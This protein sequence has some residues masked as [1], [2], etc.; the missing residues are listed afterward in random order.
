MGWQRW[1]ELNRAEKRCFHTAKQRA[2]ENHKEAFNKESTHINTLY[3]KV[4]SIPVYTTVLA[5]K[6]NK[7]L[8]SN[9]TSHTSTSGGYL[10]LIRYQQIAHLSVYCGLDLYSYQWLYCISKEDCSVQTVVCRG[11]VVPIIE[12][13][14][15]V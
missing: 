9:N 1:P 7:A 2:C 3:S 6:S 8:Q 10:N 14:A 4:N 5:R 15:A 13:M 11:E 12:P